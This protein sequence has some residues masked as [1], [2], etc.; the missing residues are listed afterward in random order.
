MKKALQILG[1][2]AAT[3]LMAA[4][5][6]SPSLFSEYSDES[7][8]SRSSFSDD[9]WQL[10]P[11][12]DFE[13]GTSATDYMAYSKVSSSG[14]PDGGPVYR[15]EIKN[16]LKNG[17]FED[18]NGVDWFHYDE[19]SQTFN[20]DAG[21]TV[22]TDFQVSDA[23]GVNL[24]LD[25][26]TA[27]FNISRDETIGIILSNNGTN[28]AFRNPD[29][30]ITD[31]NYVFSYDY[32]AI[33]LSSYFEPNWTTSSGNALGSYEFEV[34]GGPSGSDEGRSLDN[35]NYFPPLDPSSASASQQNLIKA[36]NDTDTDV[37]I[38]ATDSPQSGYIDNITFVRDTDGDFDLRLRLKM[39]INHRS[40]LDLIPGYYKFSVYVKAE[41]S[42][43]NNV[44]D[45]DRVE[46][47]INGYDDDNSMLV[48]DTM[49]F[50]K[51]SELHNLYSQS[52]ESFQGN[53]SS[54]WVQLSFASDQLIQLP[55]ISEN[56]VMELTISPSNPG[57]S[58]VGWNRLDA[59]SILI[60]E[61]TL[62]YSDT[63]WD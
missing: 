39:D 25:N 31:K 60:S 20:A 63:P 51:T 24:E 55:D 48:E 30:Y 41:N 50:Y 32:R 17:D 15:L 18:G 61:P 43:T 13:S 6:S 47:G 34:L 3:A 62:E 46:L 14:G 54:S 16:L 21:T 4:G 49:V 35:Y 26:Y 8:L 11:D 12:Y 1:I 59:G 19:P 58:D 57:T 22:P 33:S 27:Y 9:A 5:C 29:T 10:M 37:F 7:F 42:G 56:P 38:I 53:W 44:F 28:D 2:S 52:G 45:A 36:Q 40:D 23:F